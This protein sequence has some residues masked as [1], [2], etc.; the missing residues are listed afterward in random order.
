MTLLGLEANLNTIVLFIIAVLGAYTAY[1]NRKAVS[2]RKD[3]RILVESTRDLA[4][5]TELN[6]NSMKDALV[7]ATA[8]AAHAEGKE[9]GRVAGEAK[10]SRLK[11]SQGK[12]A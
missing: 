10:A 11:K 2:D 6:T 9:E 5:K 8:V 3:I 12:E 7:A 4:L 1:T